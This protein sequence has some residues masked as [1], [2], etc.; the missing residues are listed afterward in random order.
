MS[1]LIDREFKT[2][3]QLAQR[4]LGELSGPI[5]EVAV[6]AQGASGAQVRCFQAGEQRFIAKHATLLERRIMNL[7]QDQGQAVPRVAAGLDADS[8]DWMVME[9][10]EEIPDE[11][12]E[13]PVWTKGLGIALAGIHAV[14]KGKKREWLQLVSTDNELSDIHCNEW[15]PLYQGLS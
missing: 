7:L 9:F 8:R 12:N 4:A 14:N 3:T 10:A 1:V 2:V 15:Q 13:D 11:S 6:G 5:A